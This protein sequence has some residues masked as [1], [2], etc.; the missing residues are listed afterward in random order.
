MV[1]GNLIYNWIYL[2]P[3]SHPFKENQGLSRYSNIQYYLMLLEGQGLFLHSRISSSLLSPQSLSPSHIQNG[4]TQMVVVLQR[5]WLPGHVTFLSLHT[6]IDSSV[7]FASLQSLIPLQSWCLG[8]QR[9]LAHVYSSSAQAGYGQSISS[10]PSPQS[11]SWSH[12]QFWKMQR[13]L[14]HLN[15]KYLLDDFLYL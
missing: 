14:P 3:P 9:E 11:S 6:S 8:I 2:E 12:C 1:I 10:V 15:R 5:L 4:S 7:W 13:P